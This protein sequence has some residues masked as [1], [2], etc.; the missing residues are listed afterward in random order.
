MPAATESV[1]E[2]LAIVAGVTLNL[3]LFKCLWSAVMIAKLAG[4]EY[5]KFHSL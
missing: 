3:Q 4:K 5:Y 1:R 2:R